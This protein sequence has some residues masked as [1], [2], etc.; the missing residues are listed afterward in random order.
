MIPIEVLC[1]EEESPTNVSSKYFITNLQYKHMA[2][3]ARNQL[4]STS[5][6]ITVSEHEE[7]KYL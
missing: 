5:I 1:L 6:N 3:C 2:K 7:T 4:L